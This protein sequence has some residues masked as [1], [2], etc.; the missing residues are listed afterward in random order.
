MKVSISPFST[1]VQRVHGTIG[2]FKPM[3]SAPIR[4][5]MNLNAH[6]GCVHGRLEGRQLQ[7][8]KRRLVWERPVHQRHRDVIDRNTTRG[9]PFGAA[10][11]GMTME[12]RRYSV[13]IERLFQPARSQEWKDFNRLAF[14]GIS[15]RRVVEQ[16]DPVFSP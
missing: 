6:S 1:L 4:R 13:A 8:T 10:P 5:G 9:F 12:D 11:V 15:D 7:H 14:N 2:Y 3:P 16:R